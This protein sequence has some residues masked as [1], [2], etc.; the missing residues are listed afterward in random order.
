MKS[1][2]RHN[3]FL[4]LWLCLLGL[5]FAEDGR[6]QVTVDARIDSLELLVGEQAHIKLDVSADAKANLILPQLKAGDM[7]TPGV[8]VVEVSRP[9]SQ[10]LNEGARM[11]IT[12]LYTVTSF[13]SAL[14]YLPPFVVKVDG[15][16]FQSKNLALRV[17][18][19][20]VDTVHTDRFPGPKDI[21]DLPFS[22]SSDES[23]VFWLAVGLFIWVL[24]LFYLYIRFRDNK[25][26]IKIIKQAPKLP[27]HAE[28]MHEIDQIKAE[29]TWA[30]EDSKEYYTRLTEILRTY[31]KKRYGFNAMEM[32]STEIIDRLLALKDAESLDELRSLFRTADLVKFAKYNTQINENDANLVSAIEFIN[33][34]KVEADP[35]VKPK[36]DAVMVEQ[37]RSRRKL[38]G[39]RLIL[40]VLA[41]IGFALL[42]WIVWMLYNLIV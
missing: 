29:K 18:S 24:L 23:P 31:I 22:W 40:I 33:Q 5:C 27:P 28:A 19:I 42:G 21:V 8:E 12:Q 35:T 37:Q 41:A 1:F 34:T 13:D 30:K 6:A 3:D 16:E 36:P 7:L 10:Q 32:T 11:L 15:K 14:Y 25:P 9:D 39:M 20:P 26:I 38:L 17:L 4:F 2:Y